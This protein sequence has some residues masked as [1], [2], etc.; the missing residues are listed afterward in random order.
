MKKTILLMVMMLILG[1]SGVALAQE[2]GASASAGHYYYGMAALAAALGVAFGAVGAGIGQGL[3][4][5]GAVEGIARN[6]GTSG[7]VTVTLIIGLAM[8]ESL[9]IY[10]LVVALI[11]FYQ[12]PFGI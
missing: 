11:I 6:P 1:I 10:A 4:T 8:M 5:K 3:A 2:A 7:K 12:K 9:V